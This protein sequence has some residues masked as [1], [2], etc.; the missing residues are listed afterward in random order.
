MVASGQGAL[1]SHRTFAASHLLLPLLI[2]GFLIAA[3]LAVLL[4]LLLTTCAA[5]RHNVLPNNN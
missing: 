1:P 4:L 5:K 3:F 2:L